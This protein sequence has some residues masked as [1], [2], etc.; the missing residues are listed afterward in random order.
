ME[1]DAIN[2]DKFNV[3][4]NYI[5]KKFSKKVDYLNSL[6]CTFW[7]FFIVHCRDN[8]LTLWPPCWWPDDNAIFVSSDLFRDCNLL[9][10]YIFQII[11]LKMVV[12]SIHIRIFCHW[13]LRVDNKKWPLKLP[14]NWQ[15]D[16]FFGGKIQFCLYYM[17][18]WTLILWFPWFIVILGAR[19]KKYLQEVQSNFHVTYTDTHFRNKR[20]YA[21]SKFFFLHSQ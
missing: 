16:F 13:I 5:S 21:W 12:Y 3:L 18:V 19:L 2:K 7:E 17:I 6:N 9:F 14:W 11:I 4:L 20:F 15:T 10:L 1:N 8:H